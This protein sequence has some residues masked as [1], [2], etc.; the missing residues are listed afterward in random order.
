MIPILHPATIFISLI[1]H[2][3]VPY[4]KLYNFWTLFMALWWDFTTHSFYLSVVNAVGPL[5]CFTYWKPCWHG[6]YA[7][8]P[9]SIMWA[10]IWHQN[11]AL[12]APILRIFLEI[13]FFC[14]CLNPHSPPRAESKVTRKAIYGS[15]TMLF[16]TSLLPSPHPLCF[17]LSS[18]TQTYF[19]SFLS[20]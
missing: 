20:Q 8:L 4:I 16:S 13:C 9:H 19:S 3:C 5:C 6:K 1:L 10:V 11:N 14:L 17:P 15:D 2:K 7:S 18:H 12:M